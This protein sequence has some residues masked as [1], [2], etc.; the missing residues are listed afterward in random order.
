[1]P[2][3]KRDPFVLTLWEIGFEF[4]AETRLSHVFRRGRVR[5]IVPKVDHLDE[6]W[7]HAELGR[8]GLDEHQITQTI[9]AA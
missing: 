2:Y 8:C 1:V 3:I 6:E 7:A 4:V 9:R 5:I